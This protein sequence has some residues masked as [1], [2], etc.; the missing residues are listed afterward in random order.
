MRQCVHPAGFLQHAIQQYGIGLS[1]FNAASSTEL[2]TVGHGTAST[3][4]T[5]ADFTSTV[6]TLAAAAPPNTAITAGDAVVAGAAVTVK[7][8]AVFVGT[9][10][11][12]V[13]A[14]ASVAAVA[15]F[16]VAATVLLIIVVHASQRGHLARLPVTIGS[17]FFSASHFRCQISYFVGPMYSNNESIID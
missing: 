3:F 9:A 17:N 5:S 4:F 1:V 11:V 10:V 15:T 6:A 16:N 2:Y 7:V 14:I 12:A 13:A 8:A